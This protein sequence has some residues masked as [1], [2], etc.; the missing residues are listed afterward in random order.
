MS[1][2]SSI[3]GTS[4]NTAGSQDYG[5][6]GDYLSQLGGTANQY[7]TMAGQAGQNYG[8]DNAGYRT[9]LGN[10]SDLLSQ[11]FGNQDRSAFIGANT[12]NVGTAFQQGAAGATADLSARGLGTSGSMA[13]ALT[14]LYGQRSG[15]YGQAQNSAAN[16]FNVQQLSRAGQLTG[17]LG[18]AA[19]TD[20][21][22]ETGALGAQ[23]SLDSGLA[24]QYDALGSAAF[25]RQAAQNQGLFGA[26]GSIAGDVGSIYGMSQ[27]RA[28]TQPSNGYTPITQT[29][30]S[31]SP[32]YSWG[33]AAG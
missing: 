7:G 23:S 31:T 32:L 28:Q 5:L 1:T 16:F 22:R 27:G 4:P 19:S 30:P 12:A 21:G 3:L 26:I 14:G 24:N 33:G 29:L 11:G 6:A 15:A 25:Q 9:A 18:G 2:V 8:A 20:Y 13:G 17:L 10:E